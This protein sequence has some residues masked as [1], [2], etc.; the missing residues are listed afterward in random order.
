MNLKLTRPWL[1]EP[2][3]GVVEV[4]RQEAGCPRACSG[5]LLASLEGLG[6]VGHLCL[7]FLSCET[8]PSPPLQECLSL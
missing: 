6:N 3:G 8:R 1:W 4:L 7:D 2:F 5:L